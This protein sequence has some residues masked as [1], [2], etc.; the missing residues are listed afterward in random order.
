[1][2]AYYY[3]PSHI[4]MREF[5]PGYFKFDPAIIA[6][7]EDPANAD[8][9][10]LPTD[11]RHV[12]DQQILD[13]PFLDGNENRHVFFTL[14]EHEKRP[15]P[16]D[17]LAFRTDHN[18]VL[19]VENPRARA[20]CW[21]SEDLAAYVKVPDGGFRFDVHAQLW[22]SSP[23]TN[24]TVESCKEAGLAVH[25][26]R[27][28]FFYGHLETANDARLGEL[29]QSFLET[30]QASR[31][32]LVPRSRPRVNRYRFFE[33]MSM[34]RVPVLLGDD[35]LLPCA[36][37]IDYAR[38]SIR[39]GEEYAGVLGHALVDML[40]QHTETGIIEMGLYGRSMW[41]RWLAPAV[42]ERSWSELVAEALHVSG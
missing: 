25:D 13:L 40:T 9:F 39:I 28:S 23:L 33:A 18:K 2:K 24:Q 14:S 5:P 22:A 12:T 34:G 11:I 17:A 3:Q 36:D 32:V 31:L 6:S 42:W 10:V 27:N 1:M 8:C 26:Q 41:E 7:T 16:V 15:L 21:A 20:W 19:A 4:P 38:C 37:K 29:R 30:M 35:V